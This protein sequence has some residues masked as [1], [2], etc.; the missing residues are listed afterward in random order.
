MEAR[1]AELRFSLAALVVVLAT[2]YSPF[3]LV[4]VILLGPLALALMHC[5]VTLA[6]TE[7]L[8]L[9]DA[10]DG[11]R[12]HWKRGLAL[13]AITGA[14]VGLG[15]LAIAFYS[16]RGP[17]VFPLAVVVFY[18]LAF[19]AVFLMWLWPLAVYERERPSARS[20]GTLRGGSSCIRLPR[21]VS[22]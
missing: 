13:G 3:A 9:E 18:L 8:S 6:Q 10:V 22:G 7:E 20:C 19:F 2:F 14:V 12:L 4:L 17:M 16:G 21:S 15:A 1:P 11:L 5:T